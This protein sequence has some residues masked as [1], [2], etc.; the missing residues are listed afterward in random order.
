MAN[1]PTLPPQASNVGTGGSATTDHM[2]VVGVL[3][4]VVMLIILTE[5]AGIGKNWYAIVIL[6]LMG[7]L[8]IEGMTHS[9]TIL[10]WLESNPYNPNP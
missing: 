8:L 9:Q 7:P 3:V 10:P 4:M 1:N 5:V 6:L 2:V